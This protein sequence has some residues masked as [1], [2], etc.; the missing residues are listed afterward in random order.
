M[1]RPSL[2]SSPTDPDR[3]VK[4]IRAGGP[5]LVALSGGVD[6][7]L[8]A[9]LAFEALGPGALA[10]TLVG[11][12]VSADEVGRAERVARSI[13]IR[14]RLRS[15][16]PLAV[17]GYR[18]NPSDRCF[19]CRTVEAE[20]LLAEGARQGVAQYLDGVHADDLNDD[21]PGL[22]AMNR[23]GFRH[24][25]LDAGFTKEDVRREARRR[26]LPNWD[27]PS[28]ACLA[29]RVRHGMPITAELLGRIERGEA[30]VRA[31]GFR[32]VRVRI[33]EG[34]ARVEVEAD[35]VHRLLQEPLATRLRSSIAELGFAEV[36]LDARG[37]RGPRRERVVT[38]P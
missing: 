32:R 23:A 29:S 7:S 4:R 13:G 2:P 20:A 18:S 12:A 17:A 25:L 37:Y 38:P 30:L 27:Q 14:H 16:D 22:R 1:E 11:P 5:A 26:G 24:P 36:E 8:V 33:E 6:S 21:R 19:F 31:A 9:S 3:L 35:E 10:V 34:R 15:V 28:E